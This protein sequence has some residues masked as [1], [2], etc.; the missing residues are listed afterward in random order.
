MFP[1]KECDKGTILNRMYMKGSH[2][3]S[4]KLVHKVMGRLARSLD[5]HTSNDEMY[6]DEKGKLSYTR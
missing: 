4:K 6:K 3:L 5:L 1:A 2:F